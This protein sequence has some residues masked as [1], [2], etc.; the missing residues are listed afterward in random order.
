MNATV[1]HA[2]VLALIGG[3]VVM[4]SP[5]ALARLLVDQHGHRAAVD[6]PA[7]LATEETP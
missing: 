1:A 4:L 2:L 7:A 3:P 5:F 6:A